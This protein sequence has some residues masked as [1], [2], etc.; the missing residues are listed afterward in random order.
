MKCGDT[1]HFLV[2]PATFNVKTNRIGHFTLRC[3]TK[4][5]TINQ[6]VQ[7]P[8]WGQKTSTSG[9]CPMH[10]DS[11]HKQHNPKPW[12]YPSVCDIPWQHTQKL[13]CNVTNQEGNVLLC[14]EDVLSLELITPKDGLEEMEDEATLIS[15]TMDINQTTS[16]LTKQLVTSIGDIIKHFPEILEGLGK[17]PGEPY[18]IN[19]DPSLPPKCLPARPVPVHQQAAFWQQLDDTIQADII[20]PVIE[21]TPWINSY[22]IVES[23]G[24]K[25]KQKLC[26][27]LDPTPLNKVVIR[28][29]YHTQTPKTYITIF[30]RQNTSQL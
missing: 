7:V 17:F 2:L 16:V 22:V 26:I 12:K 24:K 6:I 13:T 9:T 11:V 4:S 15:S 19:V 5:K 30:T 1:H 27:C 20:V 29:P 14:Y 8:N 18:H 25:G 3:L 28:E 23:E 21:V 10:Y